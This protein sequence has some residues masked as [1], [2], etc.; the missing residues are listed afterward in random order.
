M[1]K[2][3]IFGI[4]AGLVVGLL[5]NGTH[6][7]ATD[8]NL[9]ANPSVETA[10]SDNQTPQQW[11]TGYLW[12][13]LDAS[14]HYQNTG[15]DGNRSLRVD[16]SRYQSG[17]AKWYFSPVSIAPSKQYVFQD[18]YRSNIPA[19]LLAQVQ[20]TNGNLS[21]QLLGNTVSNNQWQKF[22]ANFTAPTN[23]KQV[24]VF[25]LIQS[26]GYL[27][28]DNFF[29]GLVSDNQNG[30]IPNPSFETAN[31]TD[32][33]LPDGWHRGN[34]GTN[35]AVFNYLNTGHSGQRSVMVTVNNYKNGDAKWYY[36]PQKVTAGQ[37]Y[38]FSDYYKSNSPTK[39][40]VWVIMQDG[41]NY[42]LNLKDAAGL[43]KTSWHQYTDSFFM[44]AGA[45]SASVMHL[46]Y[47]N[48]QLITD[49]YSLAPIANPGL[50]RPIISLTFDDD[51]ESNFQT[52]MPLLKQYNYLSTQY[53]VTSFINQQDRLTTD[54][55]RAIYNAG[56][57]IGAHTVTH[58][59]L[60]T[61]S[62]IELDNELKQSKSFLESLLG[63][64]I[65]TFATPYGAYNANVITAIKKYFQS[66]RSTDAG[67][68]SKINF[69]T[70][71]IK[72]QNM[73]D[74]TTMAQFK[75]WVDTAVGQKAWL[76][77]V[78]HQITVNPDTYDTTPDALH[79]QLDVIKNSGTAVETISQAI[80][81]IQPQL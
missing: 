66:H 47:A 67:Y 52:V 57:E 16:I 55:V 25:H 24:T 37:A 14:Y 53:I 33:S 7:Q 23:A 11:L 29:L 78:Y 54:Q 17:D 20:D 61:L 31:P 34:W 28:T 45:V 44:P 1:K 69:T 72:V 39:V 48:G 74:T 46:L 81:E 21:Y 64:Q 12:G 38:Q 76:V 62:S 43:G 19:T 63:T 18:Y 49:D 5:A 26:V 56:N 71:N 35:W 8:T 79:S 73:T 58:R 80:A 77:I 42:Y 6:A 51:W 32:S 22:S 50:N 68:N 2:L 75:S 40:I 4:I 36:T 15:Q 70:D 59:D 27:E 41:S 13:N 10:S 30:G 60:T 3:T 9:I 65:K